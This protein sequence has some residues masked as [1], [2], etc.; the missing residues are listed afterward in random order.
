MTNVL[1][2]IIDRKRQVV[3][4]LRAERAGL[5]NLFT[6]SGEPWRQASCGV[7]QSIDFARATLMSTGSIAPAAA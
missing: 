4:R 6:E 1:S 7:G 5:P 3:A 2:E